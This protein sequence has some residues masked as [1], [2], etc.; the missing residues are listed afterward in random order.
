MMTSSITSYPVPQSD[1]MSVLRSFSAKQKASRRSRRSR[2]RQRTANDVKPP[3]SAPCGLLA[4]TSSNPQIPAVLDTLLQKPSAHKPSLQ[5]DESKP[6]NRAGKR[7]NFHWL[8]D[9]DV[10]GDRGTCMMTIREKIMSLFQP[11]DNK[12]AMNLFG[13]RNAV[14]KERLRQRAANN[15]V[16]HPCSYFRYVIYQSIDKRI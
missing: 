7:R 8:H 16:I 4:T 5:P 12:L 11:S 14:M 6:A 9:M 15:W 13:N 10:E 3:N 1:H 2:G